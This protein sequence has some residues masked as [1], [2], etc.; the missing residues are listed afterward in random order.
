M[1]VLK[2]QMSLLSEEVRPNHSP[3]HRVG[4]TA[5]HFAAA[6]INQMISEHVIDPSITERTAPIVYGPKKDVST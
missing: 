4:P 3:L 1:K 5:R 2:H 6:E